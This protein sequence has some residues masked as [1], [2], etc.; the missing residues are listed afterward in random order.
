MPWADIHSLNLTL[1]L[2]ALAAVLLA[3]ALLILELFASQRLSRQAPVF[4]VLLLGVVA[5]VSACVPR[6]GSVTMAAGSLA[7]LMGLAWATNN[8]V[9]R[10]FITRLYT[11]R[12]VWGGVLLAGM[13]A[14]RY[15]AA[16]VL[17]SLDH[18]SPPPVLDLEDVPI[19]RTQALTDSGKVVTLF[20]FKMHSSAAQIE[21]FIASNEKDLTQIIRMAEPNS[22]SN[23][24]GWV[25]TGGKYG[26][27]DPEVP[28]ILIDNAYEEVAA[29]RE[30]D[31]AIYIQGEKITHSGIVRIAEQHGP[32]LVESKWGPFGVY[33][34]GVKQQPFPGQCKYFR[35]K[36]SGHLLTLQ[37]AAGESDVA[38]EVANGGERV[39]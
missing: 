25:F 19:R 1:L 26:I 27:R 33:L 4:I 35:S 11:P 30:G 39:R 16:H 15:L 31:L 34:H 24:H 29:P 21:Q 5:I 8:N 17:L 9:C 18:H 36:R 23:C 28:R 38:L 2:T 10:R 3:G 22:A 37:S 32:V 6:A 14:S 13:I 12:F 20:H 7:M